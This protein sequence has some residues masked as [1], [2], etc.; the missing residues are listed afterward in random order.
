[1]EKQTRKKSDGQVFSTAEQAEE[2]KPERGFLQP[3]APP[4][5]SCHDHAPNEDVFREVWH[6]NAALSAAAGHLREATFVSC[7]TVSAAAPTGGTFCPT[8]RGYAP[9]AHGER[10]TEELQVVITP[11]SDERY[12][13]L[14]NARFALA[15]AG[16]TYIPMHPEHTETSQRRRGTEELQDWVMTRPGEEVGCQQVLV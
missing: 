4:P 16:G 8:H 6:H 12:V 13:P 5:Y 11:S 7:T 14:A 9:I 2:G 3:S 10:G 1:M 15:P